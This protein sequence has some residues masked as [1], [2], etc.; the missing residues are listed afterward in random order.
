M[1]IVSWCKHAQ[2]RKLY[3][4]TTILLLIKIWPPDRERMGATSS[5][6]GP[7]ASKSISLDVPSFPNADLKHPPMGT[8]CFSWTWPKMVR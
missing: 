2:Y 6:A 7:V 8:S 1:V 5:A 4:S 3:L